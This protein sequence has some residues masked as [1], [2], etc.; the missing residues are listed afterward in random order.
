MA[1]NSNGQ[2]STV[3][4]RADHPKRGPSNPGR[5]LLYVVILLA[6]GY[7]LLRSRQ[8]PDTPSIEWLSDYYAGISLAKQQ[9]KLVLLSFSASW[10]PACKQMK[11]TTYH[12]PKVVEFAGRFVPIM[13]DSD[14]Q[15]D[16][17]RQY[18]AEN[19]PT[20]MIVRPD[21]TELKRFIGYHSPDEFV[22]ELE[23]VPSQ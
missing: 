4:G 19:L 2:D 23:S 16:L 15:A 9:D 12:D 3:Q 6:V 20:Y 21:G 7:V 14:K 22:A 13:I 5:W 11:A 1:E 18:S 10:C 8:A 17:V